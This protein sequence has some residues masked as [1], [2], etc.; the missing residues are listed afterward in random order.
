MENCVAPGLDKFQSIIRSCIVFG[1]SSEPKKGKLPF[2]SCVEV[3]HE[4]PM[5][6][7]HLNEQV[8]DFYHLPLKRELNYFIKFQVPLLHSRQVH[9]LD[10]CYEGEGLVSVII[11]IIITGVALHILFCH[12]FWLKK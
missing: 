5:E 4:T 12:V 3:Q 6:I 11:I 7:L 1:Q 9:S 8:T 10:L 2:I